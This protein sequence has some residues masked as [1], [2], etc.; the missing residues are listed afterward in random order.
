MLSPSFNKEILP[1]S[2]KLF[3]D[4]SGEK[5]LSGQITIIYDSSESDIERLRLE[6]ASVKPMQFEAK[7]PVVIPALKTVSKNRWINVFNLRKEKMIQ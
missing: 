3:G 2:E 4:Y 5:L 6:I 7:N 1:S